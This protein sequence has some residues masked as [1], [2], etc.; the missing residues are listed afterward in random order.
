MLEGVCIHFREEYLLT[1]L[2]AGVQPLEGR[3]NL[4]A[5]LRIGFQFELRRMGDAP[6]CAK[7]LE[8]D[9]RVPHKV[10]DT[11]KN[12][13]DETRELHATTSSRS[14]ESVHRDQ[15][16]ARH[17]ILITFPNLNPFPSLMMP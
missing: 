2:K 16:S 13:Q 6:G 14:E 15:V 10:G 17:L 1:F 4:N 5:I 7:M 11:G 9:P 8:R 3:G 12:R